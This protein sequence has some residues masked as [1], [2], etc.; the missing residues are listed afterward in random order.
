MFVMKKF[1]LTACLAAVCVVAG[2]QAN[3]AYDRGYK[4][5]LELE[6]MILVNK[7]PDNMSGI[8]LVTSH[9]YCYG[10]GVY[11]GGGLALSTELRYRNFDRAM[12]FAEGKYN[13]K[14]AT[15]S[16]YVRLRTGLEFDAWDTEKVGVYFSPAIGVDFS[17]FTMS[18]SYRLSSSQWKVPEGLAINRENWLTCSF[19]I[20]F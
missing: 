15:V 16:P 2:A 20:Y 14:Y 5:S 9:G 12:I 7:A 4:G 10:N 3:E 13:L 19:G 1:I 6:N 17:R 8:A 11:L 18:L